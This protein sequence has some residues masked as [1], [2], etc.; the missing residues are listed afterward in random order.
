M[1]LPRFAATL[2]LFLLHACHHEVIEIPPER[3]Y[4]PALEAYKIGVGDVISVDVWREP[5]LST[6]VQVRPDGKISVPLAGEFVAL[7]LAPVEL[8][9]QIRQVLEAYLTSPVVSITPT[10]LNSHDYWL[11]VRI[12]GEVK[13]NNSFTYHTGMTVLDLVLAA[14]GVSDFAAANRTR[15]YRK[16]KAHDGSVQTNDYAVL[17]GDILYDGQFATNYPLQPGDIVIVPKRY[18]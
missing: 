6:S 14:G 16:I 8:A 4:V 15:L 3:A 17:L 2:C 5:S 7:G 9:T 1:F 18:F 10:Q 13:N 11:R 12:S